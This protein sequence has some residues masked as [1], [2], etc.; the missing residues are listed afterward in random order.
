MQYYNQKFNKLTVFYLIQS[1]MHKQK[2]KLHVLINTT[3]AK[4]SYQKTNH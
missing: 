4:Q 1:K 2:Y 3:K